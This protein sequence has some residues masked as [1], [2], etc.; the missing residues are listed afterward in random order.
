MVT[1]FLA[2]EK[3]F[4]VLH[5]LLQNQKVHVIYEVVIGTDRNVVNDYSKDIEQLCVAYNVKYCYNQL[6]EGIKTEYALAISWR[7]LIKSDSA[8]IIVLHD[9]ILPKYR[10][11]APLVNQLVNGEKVIGVT[12]LIASEQ[13]DRGDI[14]SQS[15]IPIEYPIKIH[16]AIKQISICYEKIV[17][18][19]FSTLTDTNHLLLRKQREED[20][21]Y[22]LWRD[23][24]DYRINWHEK[25]EKIKRFIDAVG[26]PYKGAKAILDNKMVTI[27]NVELVDDVF[28][29]NRDIGKIIFMEKGCPTVVCGEGLLLVNEIKDEEGLDLLPLKKFRAR[30]M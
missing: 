10:G 30:F 15:T 24:E 7:K 16:E 11:F 17:L 25:S 21:T 28:I 23:D 29:E 4:H 18:E 12:A 9:S 6:S 3:G 27:G 20:A 22:S 5:S 1:L 2:T 13:Y 8:K 26:F 19:I 14:I